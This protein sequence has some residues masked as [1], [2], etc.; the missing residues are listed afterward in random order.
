MN[1]WEFLE[2]EKRLVLSWNKEYWEYFTNTLDLFLLLNDSIEEIDPTYLWFPIFLS[3]I[4]THALLAILSTLR[5]HHVEAMMNLRQ[6]LENSVWAAYALRHKDGAD[7]FWP[8]VLEHDAQKISNKWYKWIEKEFKQGSDFIKRQKNLING[9]S[10]HANVVYAMG[11]FRFNPEEK[12]FGGSY[13]DEKDE[14]KIKSDL[15]LIW[16]TMMCIVDLFFWVN[17]EKNVIKFISNFI[18][19]LKDLEK[20]NQKLKIELMKNKRYKK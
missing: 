19:K 3:S 1:L 20:I 11:N 14:Y 10:A 9:S 6:V 5:L 15:W 8:T 2:E 17:K 12:S 13:F 18:Q 7:F 4:K 16:N